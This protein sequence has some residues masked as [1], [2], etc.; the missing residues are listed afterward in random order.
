MFHLPANEGEKCAN[1]LPRRVDS[2]LESSQRSS[3]ILSD[4]GDGLLKDHAR[5]GANEDYASLTTEA[6]HDGRI[7]VDSCVGDASSNSQ[8][9]PSL[10]DEITGGCYAGGA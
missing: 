1:T 9:A 6:G 10:L 3:G 2:V 8:D 7:N 5:N 4:K